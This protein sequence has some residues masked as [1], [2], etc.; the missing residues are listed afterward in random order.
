MKS[1]LEKEKTYSFEEYLAFEEKSEV[2][3]EFHNGKLIPMAGGTTYHNLISG[4]II[5]LLGNFF[6]DKELFCS[7]L[8][9]DQKVY[10]PSVNRSVYPDVT[11]V[12]G[13][14][15]FYLDSPS[16]ITNPQIIVEVLSDSTAEYDRTT[17]FENYCSIPSFREYLLVAQDRPFVEAFYLHD[18]ETALWKISRASGLEASITLLS[19]D[20]TLALKDIYRMV[21]DLKE[22]E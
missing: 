9:S 16:V 22:V 13:D 19:I 3:H 18:P 20:C 7:A 4:N 14:F 17:K 21:K 2:K 8:T 12:C 15:E 11:V 10:V 1:V 5:R 6:F